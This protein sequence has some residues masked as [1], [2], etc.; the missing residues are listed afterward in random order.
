MTPNANE[1]AFVNEF[2]ALTGFYPKDKSHFKRRRI[3]EETPDGRVVRPIYQNPP[4]GNGMYER[5]APDKSPPE[6][7]TEWVNLGKS[8]RGRGPRL[9]SIED[10]AD[11]AIRKATNDQIKL[12][13]AFRREQG[14]PEKELLKPDGIPLMG[15]FLDW[16][17][18]YAREW[19][20]E[21]LDESPELVVSPKHNKAERLNNF[22]ECARLGLHMAKICDP[23]PFR[24]SLLLVGHWCC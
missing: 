17:L 20:R 11:E 23:E 5:F 8:A 19:Y 14:V 2:K 6:F 10:P 4:E 13:N 24:A 18:W 21:K 16:C 12:E 22:S 9:T 15:A 1:S 7:E 3:V